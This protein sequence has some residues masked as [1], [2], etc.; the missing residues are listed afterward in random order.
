[1]VLKTYK[2]AEAALWNDLHVKAA[3]DASTL[4]GLGGLVLFTNVH[5]TRHLILTYIDKLECW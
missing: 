5:E 4:Q 1:M 2:M 3:S